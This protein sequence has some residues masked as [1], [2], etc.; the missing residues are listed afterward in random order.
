MIDSPS[1]NPSESV[2]ETLLAACIQVTSGADLAANLATCRTLCQ[3]ARERGASLVVLP[4]N[5]AFL[6]EHERD[7]L[8][9]AEPI[10]G[11]GPIMRALRSMARDLDLWLIAGGM[12]TPGPAGSHKV[13]NTALGLDPSGQVCARYDKIHLFDVDLPDGTCLRESGACQPGSTPT[14]MESPWGPIGLSIC[15]DLRFPELYRRYARDGARIVVVPSAFTVHTG[16]DHWHTLLR[17]RAI[18]NQ[19]FVLAPAQ[20]GAH[21]VRRSSYGHSIIVDPWG[22]IVAEAPDRPCAIVA[23]LSFRHRDAIVARMPCAQHRRL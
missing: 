16:K 7:K 11:D 9:V 4:E 10:D 18:E 23:E 13:Y 17:A 3:Q 2:P 12:A 6:G 22:T 20:F 21:N 1:E 14:L 15:Y 8:A 19:A 5:F